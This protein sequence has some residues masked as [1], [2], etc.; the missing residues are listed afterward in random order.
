MATGSGTGTV[1]TGAVTATGFTARVRSMVAELTDATYSNDEVDAFI[2]AYPVPDS[3][4]EAITADAWVPTYDL[5]AAAADIWQEKLALLVGKFDVSTD[6]NGI[7]RNQLFTN[8]KSMVKCYRSRARVGTIE[9]K[10]AP[11]IAS[12][13]LV[14][15]NVWS[16]DDLD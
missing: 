7:S 16:P 15:G 8:A 11:D 5:N 10:V 2:E 1:S 9:M 3:N 12:T 4:G 14:A 6:G 13:T